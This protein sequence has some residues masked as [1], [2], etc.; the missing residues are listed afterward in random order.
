MMKEKLLKTINEHGLIQPNQ[1]I[2][3]GLSGGP[4][5]VCLFYLLLSLRESMNL[6]ICPVH[7]NHKFRPGAAEKDQQYVEE[8][9]RKNGCSCTVFE[10]DCNRL[11]E[12]KRISSE[13]AGRLV[14]YEAFAEVCR[15]LREKGIPGGDI[16]IAVAQNADDQ[17]ET[18]LFRIL[19]G[20]GTDGLAG[21]KYSRKDSYGN[22][23]IR[24][25]LD[26]TREEIEEYCEEQHLDP[27]I[28]KTNLEP[29]YTRNK[30]RLELIPYLEK[31]FNSGLKETLVRLG[32]NAASDSD[33]IRRE[34]EKAYGSA[35]KEESGESV[36][37]DGDI[38]RTLHPAVRQRVVSRGLAVIGITEDVGAVHF[39]A[40]EDIIFNDKP[41][42]RYDLPS[43]AYITKVYS[44]VKLGIKKESRIRKVKISILDTEE[45]RQLDRT[46]ELTAA[47]DYDLMKE[48]YGTGF[49]NTVVCRTREP[50]DYIIIGNSHKK[51]LQNFFVDNKVPR[52]ERDSISLVAAG[53]EI[54]WILPGKQKGRYNSR[55][56]LC[57][58]TKKVFFIEIL[59]DL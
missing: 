55:Y 6:H 50:G 8:L 51:K 27:C 49:E 1:H 44:D 46:P 2:V 45:Y 43:G 9:C 47:F 59:R 31:T 20:A 30:I 58:N 28:D 35:I 38:L 29:V 52:D 22:I 41:S 15:N 39:E 5:S 26:I 4:D 54:L 25:L 14:R 21:I 33:F 18:I 11:A 3:T 7:I 32:K 37:F 19:R 10:A 23:I 12:E 17:A 48:E 57:Q 56:K 34:G 42:A 24:P 40:C 13:E 53:H 16:R 36:L